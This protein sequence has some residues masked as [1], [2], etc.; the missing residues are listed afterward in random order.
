MVYTYISSLPIHTP[1]Y[2]VCTIIH[3][4]ITLHLIASIIFTNNITNSSTM[5]GTLCKNILELSEHYKNPTDHI[6][7]NFRPKTNRPNRVNF[8]PTKTYSKTMRHLK[9]LLENNPSNQRDHSTF[10]LPPLCSRN[11]LLPFFNLPTVSSATKRP[12]NHP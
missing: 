6:V 1:I 8:Q 2:I 5:I 4:S 12:Q 9:C 3:T 10:K 11:Q 7:R